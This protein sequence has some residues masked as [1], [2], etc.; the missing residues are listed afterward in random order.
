MLQHE[1]H[2]LW[3]QQLAIL[4]EAPIVI[5]HRLMLF[6]QPIWSLATAQEYQQMYWEKYQATQEL[7]LTWAQFLISPQNTDILTHWQ[8]PSR[9]YHWINTT[10][11]T[12]NQAL[13]PVSSRVR[14][15]KRRLSR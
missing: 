1:L 15:N 13:R 8:S 3:Q 9:Y 6:S 14:A 12:A 4:S 7:M 11:K 2:K 5:S 10:T